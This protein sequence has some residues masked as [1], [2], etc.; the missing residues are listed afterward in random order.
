MVDLLPDIVVIR[1][2]ATAPYETRSV[3]W[4]L[5]LTDWTPWR[6]EFA[7]TWTQAA[8]RRLRDAGDL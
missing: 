6:G 2:S 3:L 4:L 7:E 8:M 1:R 5:A